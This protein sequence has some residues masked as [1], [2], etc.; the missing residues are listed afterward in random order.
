MASSLLFV[1]CGSVSDATGTGGSPG[2][3]GA[4]GGSG[5]PG[6]AAGSMAGHPGTGGAAGGGEGGSAGTRGGT[7]GGGASGGHGGAAGLAGAGGHAGAAG[8]GMAG[9]AGAGGSA[10]AAGSAGTSGSGGS[11]GGSTGQAG[12]AGAA[13]AGGTAGGTGSAGAGG[14]GGSPPVMY[15]LT[16]TKDGTGTGVVT[17]NA[18]GINCGSTCS[19]NLASGTMV[20]LT[21]SPSAGA[22]FGGWTGGGC[23]GT[24]TCVV[25]LSA[26]V[27]VM[28][29]FTVPQPILRW[30]LDDATGANTGTV[31]GYTLQF[32]GSVSAVTGKVGAG[33]VQFNS[34]AYGTVQGSARA[35]LGIDPQYTIAFWINAS[36]SPNTGSAFL[37]FENRF[38]A[39]YGGIQLYFPSAGMFALCVASTT[40]SYLTGS[41]KDVGAPAANAWHHVI[42]RYAGTGTGTGQGAGVD[43]YED[44]VLA[45]TVPNDSNNNPVF[46]QSISDMLSIGAS[47]MTLD[48]VRIYNQ[49]FSPADQCTVVIGGTW[50]GSACTLP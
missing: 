31:S 43:V 47:G 26:A 48:D 35:V 3:G 11:A 29:T 40:N 24:G 50:T 2:T 28:A 34:G 37:D 44:D 4:T 41:C 33:A 8:S 46:N 21:A 49:T 20:T 15:A 14:A 10:G 23:S 27:G 45:T 30:A 38:T 19:A 13:G 17:G 5:G 42:L 1:A 7:G 12:T 25:T 39:P 16:V 18:G 22:T 9:S 36:S 6:G 32:T